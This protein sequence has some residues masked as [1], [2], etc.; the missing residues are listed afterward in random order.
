[1]VLAVNEEANAAAVIAALT[2]LNAAPF[3]LDDVPAV[4]PVLY[5]EITVTRR[6]GG[7]PI[8]GT[9]PTSAHYRITVRSVAKT[10][11]NAREMRKR[12]SLLEGTV[13]T[14]GGLESTPIQFETAELIGEDDGY[15]SG[16]SSY[17]YAI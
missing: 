4:L 17:T 1:M 16:I 8:R 13:L 3:D 5:N 15:Y 2:T 11:S 12:S 7:A 14:V 9:L 6:Y 10:V